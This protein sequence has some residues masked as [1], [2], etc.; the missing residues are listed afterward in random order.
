MTTANRTARPLHLDPFSVQPVDEAQEAAARGCEDEEC[1]RG[2]AATVGP[3]RLDRRRGAA[4][5]AFNAANDEAPAGR[6]Q[7]YWAG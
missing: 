4:G 7:R 1:E 6:E 5:R 3:A 2:R